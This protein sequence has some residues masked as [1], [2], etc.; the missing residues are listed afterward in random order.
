MRFLGLASFIFSSL[1][2]INSFPILGY[3]GYICDDPRVCQS[4]QIQGVV[5]GRRENFCNCYNKKQRH[6]QLGRRKPIGRDVWRK[7]RYICF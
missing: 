2:I 1:C 4:N 3:I 7:V 6:A 5:D